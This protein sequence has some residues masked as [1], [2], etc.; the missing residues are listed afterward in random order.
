MFL[1]YR[2]IIIDTNNENNPNFE[3]WIKALNP[4]KNNETKENKLKQKIQWINII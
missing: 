2:I 4:R 1:I 3:I